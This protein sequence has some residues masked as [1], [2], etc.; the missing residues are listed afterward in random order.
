[1][2]CILLF[3]SKTEKRALPQVPLSNVASST[4]DFEDDGNYDIIPHSLADATAS[5]HLP[6]ATAVVTDEQNDSEDNTSALYSEVG[7]NDS[8]D[9]TEPPYS[10]IKNS[11]TEPPYSKVKSPNNTNSNPYVKVDNVGVPS[12]AKVSERPNNLPGA[13]AA[14]GEENYAAVAPPVPDKR[15]SGEGEETSDVVT[16]DVKQTSP[17]LPPR[18]MF[19][20]GGDIHPHP[21][22]PPL[23]Q[24]ED[25]TSPPAAALHSPLFVP[26]AQPGWFSFNHS[27]FIT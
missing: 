14:D 1:M 18:N 7:N 25:G 11:K 17:D 23:H 10:K 21:L 5:R 3:R 19:L 9:K 12:Y 6:I 13:I 20:A 27:I 24:D 22:S 15:F 8:K 16:S 26:Q 4:E 2:K